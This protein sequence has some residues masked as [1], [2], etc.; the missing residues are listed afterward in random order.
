MKQVFIWERHSFDPEAFELSTRFYGGLNLG[1]HAARHGRLQGIPKLN[2][3]HCKWKKKQNTIGVKTNGWKNKAA[4]DLKHTWGSCVTSVCLRLGC[5]WNTIYSWAA[6][7]QQDTFLH[8]DVIFLT[9]NSQII[10]SCCCCFVESSLLVSLSVKCSYYSKH[11]AVITTL[12]EAFHSFCSHAECSIQYVITHTGTHIHTQPTT[13]L[14]D[15][16]KAQTSKT[17][18]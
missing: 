1:H 11:C 3:A 12:N 9:L 6:E 2:I 7:R 14:R 18:F 15:T 13:G 17:R 10:T 8:E 5:V 16:A 4:E